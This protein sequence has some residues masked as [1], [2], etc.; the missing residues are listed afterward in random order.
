MACQP[1]N[2]AYVTPQ[3]CDIPEAIEAIHKAGGQAVLAHPHAYKMSNKWLR[4][5]LVEGKEWGLDG[6]EVSLSQQSPGH[7]DALAK[8]SLEY[9]LKASQGSDFHYPG[10][11]R[12]LGKNL[13]L[14]ADCVPIWE[15]WSQ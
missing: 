6:M 5:L 3:W 1:A 2:S 9:G 12:E 10:N 11:W 13:C 8:M 14:P 15:H 4:R 7:R